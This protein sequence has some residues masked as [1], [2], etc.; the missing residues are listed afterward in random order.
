MNRLVQSL[1]MPHAITGAYMTFIDLREIEQRE[2]IPGYHVRF[3]HSVNMTFAHW[4]IEA[5][6]KL[7]EHSHP[8]EQVANIIDGQFQLTIDG[9]TRVLGPGTVAVIPSN[10]VHSGQAVTSCKIIDVFYPVR[11]D[12][13]KQIA[14]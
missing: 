4:Q 5:G 9:E 11:E 6:A 12:Y 1:V 13:K 8:H 10:A 2:Q 14:A 3:V 7:P